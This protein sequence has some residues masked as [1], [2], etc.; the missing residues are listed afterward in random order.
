MGSE[1]NELPQEYGLARAVTSF[2][3][4]KVVPKGVHS[5]AKRRKMSE[6][7]VFKC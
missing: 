7:G 6:K 1:E 3:T 5:C 2:Y 4:V